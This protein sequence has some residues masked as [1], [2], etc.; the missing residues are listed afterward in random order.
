MLWGLQLKK[1]K[2]VTYKN[3]TGLYSDY[4]IIRPNQTKYLLPRFYPR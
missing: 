1:F 2:Q 3:I 4:P